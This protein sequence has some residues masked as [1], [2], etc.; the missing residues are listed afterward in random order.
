M[1]VHMTLDSDVQTR[2][3]VHA[4][5]AII[6]EKGGV[7]RLDFI[8]GDIPMGD[9]EIRGVLTSRVFMNVDDLKIL[10]DE[11]DGVIGMSE[12]GGTEGD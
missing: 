4:D 3:G 10:R 9:D 7:A 5:T 6:H 2:M 12:L 1:E 8:L 11:I